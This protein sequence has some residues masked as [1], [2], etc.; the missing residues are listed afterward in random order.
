VCMT[1][2]NCWGWNKFDNNW[3][4]ETELLHLLLDIAHKGGNWLLNVGPTPEGIFPEPSITR[5]RFIGEWLRRNGEAYYGTRN[6]LFAALPWGRSTTRPLDKGGYRVYLHVFD[7]PKDERLTIHGLKTMP[8]SACLL[9]D[10][11]GMPLAV[12]RVEE[13]VS[14]SV[15]SAAPESCV[16]VAVLDFLGMPDI[17]QPEVA[18]APDKDVQAAT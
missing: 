14:L 16:S 4:S 17:V 6:S 12:T 10:G 13:G 11:P 7:W 3:K 18:N 9:K 5:L 2:N 15:P 8:A 1:M